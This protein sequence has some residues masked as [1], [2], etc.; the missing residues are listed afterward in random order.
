[1]IIVVALFINLLYNRRNKMKAYGIPRYT[2]LQSP[3]KQD[4]L[5]FG[6][7]SSKGRL[8][9]KGGDIRSSQKATSKQATRRYWKKKERSIVSRNINSLV[10]GSIL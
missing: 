1:M 5:N 7:K 2:D 9:K 10:C 6:L 3:D 4:I 8:C